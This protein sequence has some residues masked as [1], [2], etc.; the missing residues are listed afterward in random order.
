MRTSKEAQFPKPVRSDPS[1][2][3][4][5]LWCE[6]YRTHDHKIG[7]YQRLRE[8]VAT[9]LKNGHLREFFSDHTKNKYG[10]DRDNAGPSKPAAWSSQMTIN[11]MFGGDE[12]NGVTFSVEKK[13]KISLTHGRRV[14]ESSE[15]DITFIE[16]DADGLLL[17]HND[18]LRLLEQAKLAENIIPAT[19]LL[20]GFNLTSVMTRGE[21]LLPTHAESVTK[22]TLIKVVD[23]H[24]GYNVILGRLWI[25]KTKDVPST[26]H[27][28]LKFPMP[29]GVKK[30]RGDQQAAR[31]M[32]TVTISSS[33]G[34]ETS[35]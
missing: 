28:L 17:P 3:D 16:E 21:I 11:M 7:D 6:Y 24:M 8:K 10:R 2:R 12:V 27:Q 23:G 13:T 20:A 14:Q 33:R 19:K 29:E 30:I 31:E 5:N 35:K 1:Q 26:Y 22:T 32:N 34:E 15:D 25:H 18:A 4:H 9:L